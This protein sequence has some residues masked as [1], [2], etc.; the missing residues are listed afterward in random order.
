MRRFT[1]CFSSYYCCVMKKIAIQLLSI[2]VALMLGIV[3]QA[4]VS[5]PAPSPSSTL[6]QSLGLGE[7]T[8]EYSA[9][10]HEGKNHHGKVGA[11]WQTLENWSQPTYQDYIQ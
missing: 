4:Q 1:K 11:L 7:I 8:V 2:S 5:F 6:K 3:A 10:Q 9:S